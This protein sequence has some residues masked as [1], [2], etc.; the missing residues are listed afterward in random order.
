MSLRNDYTEIA[1]ALEDYG[2]R[3]SLLSDGARKL[4]DVFWLSVAKRLMPDMP[5]KEAIA[6]L[7]ELHAAGLVKVTCNRKGL[8]LELSSPGGLQ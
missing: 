5:A 3:E 4:M 6:G 1:L 8:A 7:K 2:E